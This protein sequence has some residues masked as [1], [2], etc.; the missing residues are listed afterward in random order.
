MPGNM[1]VSALELIVRYK[2]DANNSINRES[3]ELEAVLEDISIPTTL[4]S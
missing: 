4:V 2:Q 3:F 1:S